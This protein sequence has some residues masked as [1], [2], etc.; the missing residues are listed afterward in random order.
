MQTGENEQG[1][2]KIMDLTR[3][4]SIAILLLHYYYE[5]YELFV[6]WGFRSVITDNLLKNVVR[7]GLF[8]P[9]YKAKLI[10][11]LFLFISLLGARGRKDERLTIKRAGW[12]TGTG[13]LFYFGSGWMLMI[14]ATPFAIALSYILM[15]TAGFLLV[16]RGGTILSR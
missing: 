8:Q 2:R 15:T 3:I 11:L 5:C 4:I 7:T 13:L 12:Y 14:K 10:S 9:F 1:L 6:H 16:L